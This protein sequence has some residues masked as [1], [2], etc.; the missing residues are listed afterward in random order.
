MEFSH[1]TWDKSKTTGTKGWV[2][3]HGLHCWAKKVWVWPTTRGYQLCFGIGKKKEGNKGRE[4]KKERKVL[5]HMVWVT[6]TGNCQAH[7]FFFCDCCVVPL[8]FIFYF[9]MLRFGRILKGHLFH[10]LLNWVSP[11]ASPQRDPRAGLNKTCKTGRSHW[12]PAVCQALWHRRL[13]FSAAWR[14]WSISCS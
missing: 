4:R 13:H 10:L 12:A 3:V 6:G 8:T 14:G 1:S 9:K 11:F 7:F 5:G 2:Q